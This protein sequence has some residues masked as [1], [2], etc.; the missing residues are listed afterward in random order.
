[1]N[2]V[3]IGAAMLGLLLAGTVWAWTRSSDRAM[4][5]AVGGLLVASAIQMARVL[6]AEGAAF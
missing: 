1:M 2:W 3:S 6:L 5:Y 4:P